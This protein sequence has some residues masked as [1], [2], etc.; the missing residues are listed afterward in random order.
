MTEIRK[1]QTPAVL[2]RTVFHERFMES[3]MDPAFR[4]E[5]EAISRVEAI[6]WD[7][8]REGRKAPFT[9]QAGAG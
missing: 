4:H 3:F 5:A 2:S 9:R 8:Y 6:A 1:G 7:A